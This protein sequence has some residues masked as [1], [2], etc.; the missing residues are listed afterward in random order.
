[1][2][3]LR[4]FAVAGLISFPVCA[5]APQAA[6]DAPLIV[7]GP[8]VVDAG[9]VHA[10]LLRVPEERRGNFRTSY[11]RI[12]TVADGVFIVRALAAKAKA[13][14]LDRD[15]LVQRRLQQSQDAVLA[16]LYTQK[17]QREARAVNLEQRAREL[18]QAEPDKYRSP[19]LVDV[20]HILVDLKGRTKE[21]ALARAQDVYSQATSGK[22]EFLTLAARYS[23]DP[24]KNRNGG[25]LGLTSPGSFN[26]QAREAIA[27]L[28]AKGDIS[29]PVESDA[30]FH[31]FRLVS[32]K[33]SELAKYDAVERQIVEGERERLQK[34]R[35]DAVVQDIRSSPSVVTHRDNV[36][37]LVV[38]LDPDVLKRAHELHQK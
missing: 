19:E 11:D 13:E 6:L 15:P 18:Y 31:I 23:D 25:A 34:Q 2:R 27:K 14:G 37:A 33:P 30:G 32:R 38:P 24:S 20:E 10:Y 3:I 1:M 28:K 21:M 22:E 35:A 16:D 17:V 8:V 12:A 29:A 26:P 9:D 4:L 5:Q 7:D 36:E